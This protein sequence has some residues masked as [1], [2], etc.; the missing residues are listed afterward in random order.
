[1]IEKLVREILLGKNI[2]QKEA[3]EAAITPVADDL[4]DAA[5]KITVMMAPRDFD[6]CSIVNAKS[7]ACTEDC[8]WCSQSAHYSTESDVYEFIGAGTVNSVSG[9]HLHCWQIENPDHGATK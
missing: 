9:K 8:K 3:L 1:M 4:Y 2:T 7:G 5:H 6:L